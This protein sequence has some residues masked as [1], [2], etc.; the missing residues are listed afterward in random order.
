MEV[1]PA[2]VHFIAV[3]E[4]IWTGKE[5]DRRIKTGVG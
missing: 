1:I 2:R 5:K 4:L 3:Q